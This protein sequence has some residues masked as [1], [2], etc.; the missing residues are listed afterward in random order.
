MALPIAPVAPVT[1]A[2]LT[3][4]LVSGMETPVEIMKI[5]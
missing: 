3:D 1:A 2:T 4:V 5:V